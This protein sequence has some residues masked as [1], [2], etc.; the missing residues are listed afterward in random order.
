MANKQLLCRVLVAT[1]IAGEEFAPNSLVKG[2]E[3]V[4][5]PFVDAKLLSDDKAGVD[6]CTKTLKAEVTDL[7]DKSAEVADEST[8]DSTTKDE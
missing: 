4:L 3:K 5:K 7:N 1:I 6:Y 2:D 8:D